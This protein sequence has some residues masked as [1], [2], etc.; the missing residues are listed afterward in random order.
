MAANL[1]ATWRWPGVRTLACPPAGSPGLDV[2]TSIPP[3]RPIEGTKSA[4]IVNDTAPLGVLNPGDTVNYDITIKNA[5]T[6]VVQNVRV[7]DTAPTDTVYVADTTQYNKDNSAWINI[8]QPDGGVLPL[9]VTG[10]YLLGDLNAGETFYVR[11][12]V[13]LLTGN[14]EDITNCD[15]VTSGAGTFRKCV[16]T[17]VATRDCGRLAQF[18]WNLRSPE[19]AAPFLQRPDTGLA[20]G[21]RSPRPAFGQR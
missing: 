13:T 6:V 15:V 17:P 7:Y 20:L 5:G 18:L 11:F 9:S 10:G 14:Y 4:V 8:G 19:W 16:T 12:Q 1:G 2:G 21:R 3:L